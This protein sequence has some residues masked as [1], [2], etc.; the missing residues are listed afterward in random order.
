[1]TGLNILY[2]KQAKEEKEWVKVKDRDK[3]GRLREVYWA[4]R[5]EEKIGGE[6]SFFS[7]SISWRTDR[8][9][10]GREGDDPGDSFIHKAKITAGA[11]SNFEW[12]EITEVFTTT[13][14]ATIEG[15]MRVWNHIESKQAVDF[16]EFVKGIERG[17]PSRCQQRRAADEVIKAIKKKIRKTSYKEVMEKYGYGTLVVGMP[18]W[19]AVFPEDPYRAENALD[20]FMVRTAI[21]MEE[22]GQKELRR[23]NCPFKHV[24]VL[25]D[26]TPEAIDE[27]EAK[28]SREYENVVN[29]T[30][31]NPLPASTL[32]TLSRVLKGAIERTKTIESEAPSC[33]LHIEKRVEKKKSGIGPYPKMVQILEKM[34]KEWTKKERKKGIIKKWKQRIVLELCKILCFIKIHGIV[35]LERW[36]AQ[37]LS[38]KRY[39]R[40]KALKRMA[41]RLYRES[42]RRE[43]KKRER[44]Q[45]MSKET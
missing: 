29:S 26:T 8:E 34:T 27:W 32:A 31:M 37:K 5:A 39:L 40:R 1:M 16:K 23:K 41:L 3:P 2:A 9:E 44:M 24:I 6:K 25:W 42:V 35:G 13:H 33:C 15:A 17:R 38:P 19:F 10:I 20:D 22:I 36:A 45:H 12:I 28:R 18:L 11:E 4:R 21:G 14:A 7:M 43:Q 30:L